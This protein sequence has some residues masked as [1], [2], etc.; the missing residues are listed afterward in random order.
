MEENENVINS[1]DNG[2][3]P[4]TEQNSG[5]GEGQREQI[6][7]Q[8]ANQTQPVQFNAE[9]QQKVN[10]L[11]KEEKSKFYS[12][13]GVSKAEE[14]DEL[15][16]AGREHL[17]NKDKYSTLN[18]ENLSLRAENALIKNKVREDMTEVVQNY[19]K[20]AGLELNAK[21]LE[22]LFTE[23]PAL[24]DQWCEKTNI[25]PVII[26]NKGQQQKPQS[27]FDKD[28]YNAIKRK[29]GIPY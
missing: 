7:T 19:F 1:N 15:V 9:Q 8:N 2:Q 22:Q 28:E 17:E 27:E 5:A 21:N 4:Q 12:K 23:K 14:L 20:G 16:K 18:N 29:A 24:K 10:S 26:G 11:L 25:E 13:Y 3:E 6:P